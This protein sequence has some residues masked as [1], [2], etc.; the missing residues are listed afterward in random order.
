MVHRR[1]LYREHE[2]SDSCALA[3]SATR[4]CIR[5][6]SSPHP[7]NW[8]S[9]L[10]ESDSAYNNAYNGNHAADD[11]A[12]VGREELLHLGHATWVR[13]QEHVISARNFRGARRIVGIVAILGEALRTNVRARG[14]WCELESRAVNRSALQT[15]SPVGVRRRGVGQKA[16]KGVRKGLVDKYLGEKW[17]VRKL[18]VVRTVR[19]DL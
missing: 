14:R 2:N 6:L 16:P 9:H 4:I 11:L 13:V 12:F 15:L 7:N 10:H 1:P 5:M 18:H 17:S 3:A 19:R 8:S